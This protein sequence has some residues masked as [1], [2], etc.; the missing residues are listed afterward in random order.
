MTLPPTPADLRASRAWR[1]ASS[2]RIAWQRFA[3][4]LRRT[5]KHRDIDD[6]DAPHWQDERHDYS[7]HR[8]FT[9]AGARRLLLFEKESI[10]NAFLGASYRVQRKWTIATAKVPFAPFRFDI[11][12]ISDHARRL[13]VPIGFVGDADPHG[14]HVFGALRSGTI[15]APRLDGRRMKIEWLGIDDR[16]LRLARPTKRSLIGRTIQMKWVEREYWWVVKRLM[17]NIERLIGEATFT[18]LE[19]GTKAEADAFVDIL[20]SLLIGRR[21]VRAR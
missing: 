19:T 12:L 17:P 15:D 14:I 21:G 3:G 13:G 10:Q 4:W 16:W 7:D 1:E 9:G 20:P 11:D 6:G 2:G 5:T 18:M 8:L